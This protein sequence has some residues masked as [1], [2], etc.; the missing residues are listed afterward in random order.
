MNE[1]YLTPKEVSV[2]ENITENGFKK[3]FSKNYYKTFQYA[4]SQNGGGKNGKKLE[5]ALSSLSPDAQKKYVADHEV[6][7]LAMQSLAPEAALEVAGK[8]AP[9][10]SVYKGIEIPCQV[11]SLGPGHRRLR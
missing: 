10:D 6:G 5:I 11:R 3:R 4:P 2:L 1:I 9:W 7:F 8:L